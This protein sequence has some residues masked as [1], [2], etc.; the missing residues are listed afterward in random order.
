MKDCK[1]GLKVVKTVL[2]IIT[3]RHNGFP[4]CPVIGSCK[5][6]PRLCV[7]MQNKLNIVQGL[8]EA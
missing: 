4:C 2:Q 7:A 1:G 5:W 6:L 3:R 8:N